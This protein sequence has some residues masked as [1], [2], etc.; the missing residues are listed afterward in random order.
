MAIMTKHVAPNEQG[1]LQGANASLMG[2]ASM[3]GPAIFTLSY[4]RAIDPKYG[5]DLPGVP[6][7]LAAGFLLAAMFTG[8]RTL[9][10]DQ[11]GA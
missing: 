6:F 2:I 3:I 5:F 10:G 7:L 11:A 9:R 8:W 1:Q 4:A